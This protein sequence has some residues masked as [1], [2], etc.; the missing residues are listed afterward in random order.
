MRKLDLVGRY[1]TWR[2]QCYHYQCTF[3]QLTQDGRMRESDLGGPG[4]PQE[5]LESVD[6]DELF[7]LL[8]AIRLAGVDDLTKS[9]EESRKMLARYDKDWI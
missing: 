8:D 4:I 2:D 9:I 1:R 6:R 7:K 5:L 3:T